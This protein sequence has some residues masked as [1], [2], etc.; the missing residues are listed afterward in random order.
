MKSNAIPLVS[1]CIISLFLLPG[2][3]KENPE[4]KPADKDFLLSKIL[5]EGKLYQ[6]YIYNNNRKLIRVNYY[7]DDSVYHFESYTYN[8]EGKAVVKEYSDDYYETYEYDES[9]RYVKLNQHDNDG[10]IYRVTEFTYD[11]NG[12]IEKGVIN[13]RDVET[14]NISY[15]YDSSGN[16]VTRIEGPEQGSQFSR[17]LSEFEYDDKKNPR[18]NW[19]LPTDIVQ[20]NN[21][22]RYY[23]ENMLSCALPPNYIYQYEY[24]EDG[25]PVKEIRNRGETEVYDTFYYEYLK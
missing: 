23:N 11:S 22:L 18:Y 14:W 15:S 21:P 2:C 13:F 16:V 19:G 7:Y 24:N 12:Q 6:E 1:V 8:S 9:G 4:I 17:S 20:Y 10:E 5:T 3:E 25:Y